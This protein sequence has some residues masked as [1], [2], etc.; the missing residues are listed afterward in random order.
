MRLHTDIKQVLICIHKSC[1]ID[2]YVATD[3]GLIMAMV[4]WV[5]LLWSYLKVCRTIWNMNA[6]NAVYMNRARAAGKT[7]PLAIAF[8]TIR[9]YLIIDLGLCISQAMFVCLPACLTV[10]RKDLHI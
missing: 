5:A 6:T 3:H 7:R 10:Q 9:P 8:R 4:T 1:N 2:H